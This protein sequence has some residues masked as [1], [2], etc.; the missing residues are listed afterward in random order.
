MV[1]LNTD[2]ALNKTDGTRNTKLINDSIKNA[3]NALF[4]EYVRNMLPITNKMYTRMMNEEKDYFPYLLK[5][6]SLVL[7][8]IVGEQMI[9]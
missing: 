4:R 7:N 8:S 5:E 2:I 3:S 9:S 6:S 1:Y